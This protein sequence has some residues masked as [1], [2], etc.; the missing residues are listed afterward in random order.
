MGYLTAVSWL[1]LERQCQF[2]QLRRP[3]LPPELVC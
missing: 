3:Q 1:I 2:S